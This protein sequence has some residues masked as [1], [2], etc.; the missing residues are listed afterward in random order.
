MNSKPGK[1][2]VALIL[3]GL[4]APGPLPSLQAMPEPADSAQAKQQVK[5]HSSE[6]DA[7]RAKRAERLKAEDGWLTLVALHWLKPGETRFGSDPGNEL[8]LPA[9]TPALAG[10]LVLEDAGRVRLVPEPGT[11]LTVNGEAATAARTLA[12]DTS[13][14]PDTLQVG[15]VRLMAIKRGERIGIR[16]K[17][18][19]SAVRTGFKGLSYFPTDAAYRIEATWVPYDKPKEIEVP[20]VLGTVEKSP[21]PG[22]AKFTLAGRE[23]SLEPILEDPEATSLFYIFKDATSGKETY[24]AGRFLYGPLP[25]DGK[26]VLDFNKAYSPPCAFTSFATCPLPPRQNRLAV[27]IEAG[28]KKPAGH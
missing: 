7:W 20:N 15:P 19:R 24:G 27:R 12:D 5:E 6:I 1:G 16:A 17:D 26:V 11:A 2:P 13:E 4:L 25:K 8:V 28:E 23:V 21:A 9:G 14:K 22:V 18:P 3:L 10:K